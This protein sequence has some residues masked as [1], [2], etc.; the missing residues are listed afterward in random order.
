M[1]I[2]GLKTNKGV[3]LNG[4]ILLK[5]KIFRDQR[6][7]FYESFNQKNFMNLLK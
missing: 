6:G 5:P 2:S 1:K 3:Y 7:Y 4:P